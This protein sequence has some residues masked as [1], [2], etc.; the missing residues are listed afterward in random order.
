MKY[1]SKTGVER[2][3]EFV[4]GSVMTQVDNEE[5][6]FNKKKFM[7]QTKNLSLFEKRTY[8]SRELSKNL[9]PSLHNKT[10]FKGIQEI[11]NKL[12]VAKSVQLIR[13]PNELGSTPAD[14]TSSNPYRPQP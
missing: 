13:R 3:E 10:H 6:K 8:M 5:Y 12:G 4:R 11:S 14:S 7:E 2:V 1:T 9:L